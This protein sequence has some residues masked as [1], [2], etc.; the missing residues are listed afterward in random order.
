MEQKAKRKYVL[1]PGNHQF[2]PKGRAGFNNSNTTDEELAWYL[3][4]FPHITPLFTV[5]NAQRIK[6]SKLS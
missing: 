5:I 2:S 4:H 3:E 1:K 6:K